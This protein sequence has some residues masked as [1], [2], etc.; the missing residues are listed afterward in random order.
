[1]A[2]VKCP[3]CGSVFEKVTFMGKVCDTCQ[4][5]TLGQDTL[6]LSI[7]VEVAKGAAAD[8]NF[9]TAEFTF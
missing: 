5:C 9:A 6:G 3:L 2:T 1:M 4:L 8:A 7:S